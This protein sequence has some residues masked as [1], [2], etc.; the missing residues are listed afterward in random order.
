MHHLKSKGNDVLTILVNICLSLVP[1]LMIN[2]LQSLL[3][4]TLSTK[5]K[6]IL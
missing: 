4:L 5:V 6:H 3:Y 2:A 1:D